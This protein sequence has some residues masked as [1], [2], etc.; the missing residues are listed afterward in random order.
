M[1]SIPSIT[2]VIIIT[3]FLLFS[4]AIQDIQAEVGVGDQ[5][6]EFTLTDLDGNTVSLSDFTGQ[7]VFLNF[8]GYG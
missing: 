1:R 3:G 5:A 4:I 7:V 2:L 8:L 6:P